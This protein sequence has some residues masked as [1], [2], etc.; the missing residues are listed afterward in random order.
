MQSTIA[1]KSSD[2]LPD[3][4]L[5]DPIDDGVLRFSRADEAANAVG[6]AAVSGPA[7]TGTAAR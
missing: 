5:R 1:A 3:R 4:L 7:V 2:T 6:T